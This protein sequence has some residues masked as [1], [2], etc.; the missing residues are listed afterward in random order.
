[1]CTKSESNADFLS[2]MAAGSK[3]ELV[4]FDKSDF[5]VLIVKI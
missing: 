2:K 5:F 4:L 3:N 1:M